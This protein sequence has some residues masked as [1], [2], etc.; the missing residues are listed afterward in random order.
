[1]KKFIHLKNIGSVITLLSAYKKDGRNLKPNDCDLDKNISI[2]CSQDSIEYVG[3]DQNSIEMYKD[4]IELTVNL[5]E[6]SVTP[7]VVDSHTHLVFGG[8]RSDEYVKRLNG[9]SYQDIAKQGGGINHTST[10]TNDLSAEQLFRE[11]VMKI[12][13][14]YQY[15][16]GTIEIKSGYG[17]NVEKEI[18]LSKIIERLKKHFAP[19]VQILNTFMA[20]H[21]IPANYQTSDQYMKEVCIPAL[22]E[23][24]KLGIIDFVDIFHENGYFSAENVKEL[25]S[26]CH[27][28]GLNMRVHADEFCD[29]NGAEIAADLKFFSADHLLAISDM[30][31]KALANS[32]TVATLLPGTG[33]FLGKKQAP[34]RKL[35]DAG[36]KVAI[37]SDFN[38]GSCHIDNLI[39]LSNIAAP[40]YK[41][42]QAELWSS[43]TLNAAHSLGLKKQGAII[44]G[45]APRFS[46]FKTPDINEV[47]YSWTKNLSERVQEVDQFFHENR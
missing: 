40:N 8:N 26:V 2:I 9:I 4:R 18:E 16:V 42:N 7:E 22:K 19:R 21:A 31:V 39:L 47:T 23:V 35:L 28:L 38:P 13:Q 10:H 3:T 24:S 15:G 11:S 41:L 46:F 6:Y 5:R 32:S 12:E 36:C 20:A 37:A 27:Q 43:I 33:Y 34:A 17:L 29:N 14:I 25:N 44:K 30:G 45:L 1:M